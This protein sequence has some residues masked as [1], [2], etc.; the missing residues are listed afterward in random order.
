MALNFDNMI[1]ESL[2]RFTYLS[3]ATGD[4]YFIAEDIKDGTLKNGEEIV[5]GTGKAG[6]RISSLKKN[7]TAGFSFSNAY[8]SGNQLAAQTGT[9]VEV[10]A[11]ATILSPCIDILTVGETPTTV[12]T[13]QTAEGTAGAEIRVIYKLN[14]DGTQGAKYVQAATAS[15]TEFSYVAATKVLTLP[16]GSVFATGDKVLAVYEF[17]TKGKKFS[18]KSA[19]FSKN[20]KAI[21]EGT[22]KSA[23]DNETVYYAKIVIPNAS[24]D[25]SFDLSL[26]GDQVNHP[27]T[28]ESQPSS[29][30]GGD[31]WYWIIEDDSE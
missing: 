29:C 6:R 10:A 12:S 18:N 5:W 20:G 28:C 15:A 25:G 11:T 3:N 24:G 21:I 7:K 30:T 31:L 17:N 16:T 23:C 8:V 22:V 1:F 26:G 27:F 2:D 13:T 4:I 19:V 9:D 14:L